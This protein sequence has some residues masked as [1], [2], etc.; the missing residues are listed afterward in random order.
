M[1]H[2]PIGLGVQGLADAF[3]IMGLPFECEEARTLYEDI[4]ETIYFAACEESCELAEREGPYETWAG[5]PA[6][7]G[8]LQFDLGGQTLPERPRGEGDNDEAKARR[9]RN[10]G[11][12]AA[13]RCARVHLQGAQGRL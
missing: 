2:R 10:R 8:K 13:G 4:F 3:F 5:S 9:C 7:L 1:K 12:Q 11:C 6:S